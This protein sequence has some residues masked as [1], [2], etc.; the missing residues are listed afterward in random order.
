MSDII[1]MK[2]FSNLFKSDF[3]LKYHGIYKFYPNVTPYRINID[4]MYFSSV[5]NEEAEAE[6]QATAISNSYKDLSCFEN[7][8]D[9]NIYKLWDIYQA[10]ASK[11]SNVGLMKIETHLH[12]IPSLTNIIMLTPNQHSELFLK[13]VS[14]D[15]LNLLCHNLFNHMTNKKKVTGTTN[16]RFEEKIVKKSRV[17]QAVE[18][19]KITRSDA[20]LELLNFVRRQTYYLSR[21]IRGINN[22]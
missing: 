3:G 19:N 6:P 4:C 14:V 16:D 9:G 21:M 8:E 1:Q 13:I 17:I 20:E 7:A 18:D 11:L 10:E 22:D 5:E 15:T 2:Y 12:E